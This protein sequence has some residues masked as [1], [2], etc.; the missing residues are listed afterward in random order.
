MFL[1]ESDNETIRSGTQIEL[2]SKH[3][4]V[5]QT[6][7][8]ES[9]DEEHR[10][11]AS[12]GDL[13]LPNPETQA[14]SGGNRPQNGTLERAQSLEM[15]EAINQKVTP[16]KR[17][18][19]SASAVEMDAEFN[20]EP[21]LDMSNLDTLQRGRLK[22]AYEWGNL[23]DAIY[24]TAN[25][26]FND[27]PSD[28]DDAGDRKATIN[29]SNISLDSSFV[30]HVM[31]VADKFDKESSDEN[32]SRQMEQLNQER[33]EILSKV[34]DESGS[35]VVVIQE[36]V[37]LLDNRKPKAEAFNINWGPTEANPKRYHQLDTDSP[38]S[39]EDSINKFIKSDKRNGSSVAMIQ[40]NE[41]NDDDDIDNNTPPPEYNFNYKHETMTERQ[42]VSFQYMNTETTLPDVRLI[43]NSSTT[44]TSLNNGKEIPINI[45]HS[46]T[47]DQSTDQ[48]KIINYGTNMPDDV[49]V[50]RYPLG[51]LEH[52]QA[53][54]NTKLLAQQMALDEVNHRGVVTLNTSKTTIK[55]EV[56]TSPPPSLL[57]VVSSPFASLLASDPN[58]PDAPVFAS[59][60]QGVNS[61]SISSM[62]VN[63]RPDS[64]KSDTSLPPA[65][66]LGL[67][68]V[69]TISTD[70]RG[71]SQPSSIIL[72]DD[73][74]LD[75]TLR[76]LESDATDSVLT[77]NEVFIIESLSSK[78]VPEPKPTEAKTF[79]TEIRVQTP[80]EEK[81][82]DITAV[83]EKQLPPIS[84]TTSSTT[85][86]PSTPSPKSTS[87]Q[88]SPTKKHHTDDEYGIPRNSEIRFTT[89]T[90][91]SPSLQRLHYGGVS[92]GVIGNGRD[93]N[94]SSQIDHIRS[95]FE[96]HHSQSE[97]PV[98][99]RKT[100]IP[101]LR[102]SPSK[103]PVFNSAKTGGDL[104]R[105]SSNGSI[106]SSNGSINN[107]NSV[108][109]SNNNSVTTSPQQLNNG[110][111]VNVTVTSIKNS[112]RNPSG[113]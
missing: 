18:A 40:Q 73:E 25:G 91:E 68:N 13:S 30:S 55:P 45:K 84:P 83:A 38:K 32:V 67:E 95:T 50:S 34:V 51:S 96:R 12:L 16:K 31:S 6:S 113:K 69:V 14:N 23:E 39:L 99:V 74:H 87:P 112:S 103:I 28:E 19:P 3:I 92:G 54:V 20:K 110:H 46:L 107:N 7:E 42:P 53:A 66:V 4:T 43:T 108:S 100:S 85:S 49:K 98:P 47:N 59:D 104:S 56:A 109:Y 97:I 29:A 89:A 88:Q 2:G 35:S 70:S 62:E 21:R 90:Y 37:Q 26:R 86:T 44:T 64:R 10:R 1:A 106:H 79:I 17:K 58:D 81:T 36:K 24:D 76:S 105:K 101:S 102:T 63:I 27:S 61:I 52:L 57:P 75:F 77:K 82:E 15:T 60:G 8:E 41:F 5:H 71:S 94:R 9:D 80:N 11:T 33:N 93:N 22:G 111:R 78:K 72:I 48:V 65:A